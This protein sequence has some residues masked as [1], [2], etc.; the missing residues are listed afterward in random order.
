MNNRVVLKEVEQGFRM[1]NPQTTGGG[2]IVCPE[3]LYNIMLECWD[4][5]P[6]ARP[7]FQHLNDVFDNWSVSTESQYLDGQNAWGGHAVGTITE[8]FTSISDCRQNFLLHF[9]NEFLDGIFSAK[10]AAHKTCGKL[11]K[12]LEARRTANR[13][14]SAKRFP[15]SSSQPSDVRPDVEARTRKGCA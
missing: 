13:N 11:E 1:P 15:T 9:C 3:E 12:M 10:P 8:N 5:R 14:S 6:E 4:A 7:T 2:H